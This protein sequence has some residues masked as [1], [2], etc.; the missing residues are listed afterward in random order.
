VLP[1]VEKYD[2]SSGTSSR[3]TKL[4][5][6][7]VRYLEKAIMNLDY[8]Q[9]KMVREALHERAT[10][11]RIA[12]H[13]SYQ[14]PIM[15][16]I[17]KLWQV[18]Y[19]WAGSKLYDIFA[20]SQ[21]L[22]SSYFLSKSKALEKFPMLSSDSLVG[23]MVYY[24]GAHNDSRTNIALALTAAT[25]G[26]T[27]ANHV[28]VVDLIRSRVTD[29][30]GQEKEIVSGAVVRD[31]L[32]GKKWE[33]KAKG[34]INAT[35][36]FADKLRQIDEGEKCE[37]LVVPS[38]GVHIVLP[39][40]YSPRDM[41]LL[42]PATSDGRVI[43]F[44]PWEGKTLSGTT[45]TPSVITDQPKPLEEEISFILKEVGNY[46]NKDVAVR[47]GDV[48]AAWSGIRPLVK[49]PTKLGKS[50]TQG[51]ARNHVITVSDS[52]L[53]TIV[54]GKWTTYR[55]MA[56]E[57]VARAIDEFGLK[58]HNDCITTQVQLIGA[59]DWT[60]TMFIK[61]IQNYGVEREAAQHLANTYGDRSFEVAK[62]A[63]PTGKRWPVLG[64][65]LAEGYPYLE[66]EVIYSVRYEYACTAED[67]L[68]RRTRLAFLN[69]NVALDVLPRVIDIMATELKWD[70]SR[71]EKEF[72]QTKQFLCTMGLEDLKSREL[73]NSMDILYYRES[74]DAID[75]EHKGYI[76]KD[77]L[78]EFIKTTE[79]TK[80]NENEI[81]ELINRTDKNNG[82]IEF[83]EFV[84]L[85][86]S[87]HTHEE[88]DK[89]RLAR[90]ME[91]KIPTNRSAG[92]L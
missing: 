85:M 29:E 80:V 78:R 9:Y 47:R 39:D 65:P 68:A 48:L 81:E 42:D 33:V 84:E 76:P 82:V 89:H 83:N 43:Y 58:P 67:V 64:R 20:G 35:G 53:L 28:E 1:L 12:P 30:S 59:K 63:T 26:A 73:L 6:G 21:R 61:L 52:K 51:L 38:S 88:R 70:K 19:F 41:G 7:G 2:F 16:P 4:I 23:A 11:L 14:M 74:F 71:K 87:I 75:T 3:S 13:L 22:E 79:K 56:E 57:A 18:P 10:V 31:M 55:E 49:D 69:A 27:V 60:P 24:D 44:L 5:H 66:E 34:V 46:L 25:Y 90:T 62:L 36:P 32:T 17:Y 40:Y 54:G 37:N 15:L 92:G 77:K 72:E 86:V 45:D 8:E 50:G 91:R